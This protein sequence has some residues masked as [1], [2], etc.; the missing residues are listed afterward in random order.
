MDATKEKSSCYGFNEMLNK[1]TGDEDSLHVNVFTKNLNL[2]KS[3]PVMAYIYGGAFRTG[4][5]TPSIYGPDFLLIHDVIL[6]TI[7]YRVG[8]LGELYQIQYHHYY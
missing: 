1:I 5:N 4:S 7:N 2:K 8:A 6:V 3:Y